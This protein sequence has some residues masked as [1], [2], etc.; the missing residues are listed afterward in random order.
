MKV[1][2]VYDGT[3]Q[4]KEALRYGMEKMKEK[5]GEV[6]AFHVFNDT[7]FTGYDVAGAVERAKKESA[8]HLEEAKSI[9]RQA[10]DDVRASVFSGE[11]DPEEETIRFAA[12]RKV[13]VLL[14]PPKY[15]SLIRRFSNISGDRGKQLAENAG[16]DRAEKLKMAVVAVR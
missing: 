3:L 12:E 16:I 9:V 2:V 7:L 4:S 6:I 11:G 13:D 14:C 8:R 1:L 10:A 15:K 5:G